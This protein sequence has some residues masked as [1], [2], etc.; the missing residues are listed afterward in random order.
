MTERLIRGRKRCIS[1]LVTLA[2]CCLVWMAPQALRAQVGGEGAI[3]GRVTDPT[4]AVIPNAV[5]S[6]TNNETGV[7]S[8]RKATGTGNYVISPLPAGHYT[9]KAIAAGF[10][11]LIQRNITVNATATTALDLHLKVGSTSQTVTVTSA[12][13]SLDKT[14]GTLSVTMN[15]KQYSSL[16]LSMGGQ[17]RDPTAFIYLMPGVSGAGRTGE[18]DGQGS[19]SGLSAG[20]SAQIYMDGVPLATA[21][22]GDN[23]T[24][25][26]AVSVDAVNQFQVLTSSA[27]VEFD[28]LGS[29]NFV[30]KSG[31]NQ[32]HGSAFDYVRN[33]VFDSWGFFNK[34]LTE[35]TPSGATVPAPK[36]PEHQNEFGVSFGGPVIRHKL[37]FF[38]SYD[39]FHYTTKFGADLVTVPTAAER[40]GDF[41]A[42]PQPIYDPTT[43]AACTAANGG[44]PCAYQFD[45][46]K[47]GV[48][49]LNVI[50]ANEISDIS[51]YMQKFLPAPSNS[52][53]SGNFLYAAPEGAANWEFTSRVDANISPKQRLSFIVNSGRRG[54]IGLDY[55]SHSLLPP[56]YTNGF[57]V[58]E[59]TTNGIVEDTYVLTPHVVNDLKY[60]YIRF[61]GSPVNPNYGNQLYAAGGDVGIKGL[62]A[63]Q[64]SETFPN[65]GFSGGL[66]APL[67]WTSRNGYTQ[68]QNT[69][70]ILD[71]I[72]WSR[73]R[74]NIT[75]G[76]IYEWINNNGSNFNTQTPP[77]NL[78]YSNATT[79]GYT[80]S[81]SLNT[82]QT[83]A[84]YASFLIGAVNSS[85]MTIQPF[86]T[87]GSR[88]RVFAPYAQDNYR[89]TSKL[90]L[91]YGL[92]WDFYSPYHEV[93]NR[94]SFLNPNLINPIT[95]T[96]GI[97]EFAGHGVDSCDCRTP[98]HYY[99]GNAAPR[100][101]MAYSINDKTVVRGG[102]GINYTHQGGV[103]GR[104]NLNNGIS[105]AGFNASTSYAPSN[106]GGTPAFYLNSNLGVLSNN[107]LPPYN[108]GSEISPTVNTGN[109]L[110]ANGNG[111]TASGMTYG[112]FHLGGRPPYSETWN[113][114]VQRAITNA[115]TVSL[116]YAGS[117]SHFLPGGLNLRGYYLNQLDPKY[118]VL[119]PLLKQYPTSVDP[120]TGQTYLQEAQAILP[121]INLPYP[122]F[123]GKQATIEQ[124]LLPFPQYGG[125]GDIWGDVANSNYNSLQLTIAERMSHGL[126]FNFNYT[127][128]KELDNAG[129]I[130]SGYAIPGSAIVGGK[131]WKMD[132]IDREQG[133]T[134][135]NWNF[136]GVYDLPFGKGHIGNNNPVVRLL[137]GNWNLSW[138]ASYH[139]GGPLQITSSGCSAVGQGTCFPSYNPAFTGSVRENGHWGQ[140]VNYK[141]ASTIHFMNPAA[142][143][144][145]N[146]PNVYQIGNVAPTAPYGLFGPG[147][148]D[149]DA[150]VT[151]TFPITRRINFVFNAESFNVT[152][153]VQ[154]TGI[155]TNVSSSGFGTVSRQANSPRDWQFAGRINF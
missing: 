106:Q 9:V 30:I 56:P 82:G 71:D 131:S 115:M 116:N 94:Y 120:K 76:G 21:S 23:R 46:T 24:V 65:T 92:R 105:Q 69:Y 63:G 137:A 151:R 150:G 49:T 17:Q 72:Q 133:G 3:Q 47:N 155:N 31:T 19:G 33:T 74:H 145:P 2:L 144:T 55:G 118:L 6:A 130:R 113:F 64:A 70:D 40:T 26:L 8:S 34:G 111:V 77:L 88:W 12:P 20:Q 29:Q 28:G 138:I 152:N 13:P 83:G 86:S 117:Q 61:T 44:V 79:A 1:Q 37:F 42:Y 132:R 143:I 59:T 112:D 5:V 66:D 16:P 124:M 43:R 109:Y 91:T 96:P 104:I 110:D 67:G 154:F 4:G 53:A 81:G 95:G 27:P 10:A 84:A 135:Q 139:A 57:N 75:F 102:F 35:T 153:T 7:V 97:L 148:Y 62:P 147:G 87:L 60:A 54:F 32:F 14:D 15:N 141:N 68:A 93:Q 39:K 90:T 45:G 52:S 122:N 85:G 11:T 126:S 107:S 100:V 58:P 108:V 123:G 103:G 98:V 136:Y 146:N 140:G 18:M 101:G 73:G 48:P 50:P 127:W 99:Y 36:S 78:N 89:V 142:F 134:P 114:G 119:G 51:K 129:N 149:I 125:I 25:S 128:S 80:G 38:V 22:Q 41:S 121:G